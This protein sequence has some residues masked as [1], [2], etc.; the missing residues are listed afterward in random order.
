[1]SSDRI[2]GSGICLL[3]GLFVIST[4]Q[5]LQERMLLARSVIILAIVYHRNGQGVPPNERQKRDEG[6]YFG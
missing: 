3:W 6:L 1:M 2:F 5:L 4:F